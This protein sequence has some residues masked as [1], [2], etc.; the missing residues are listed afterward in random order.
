MRKKKVNYLEL[1]KL[2][3]KTGQLPSSG[4]CNSLYNGVPKRLNPTDDDKDILWQEG[5]SLTFWAS[6][7]PKIGHGRIRFYG[8]NPLRQNIVL[9]L[10]AMNN[11]L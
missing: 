2:W 1:Y 7:L 4:L 9:L 10:A 8:F 3:S 5:V 11:Q 6:D